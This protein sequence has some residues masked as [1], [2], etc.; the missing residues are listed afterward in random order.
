META[1]REMVPKVAAGFSGA[2]PAEAALAVERSLS[3]LNPL[4]AA[5]LRKHTREVLAGL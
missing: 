2:S 4:L 3:I 1:V 5:L